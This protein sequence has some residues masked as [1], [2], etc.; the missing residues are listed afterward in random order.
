MTTGAA[1]LI[2]RQE[3]RWPGPGDDG[4]AGPEPA[5][6]PAPAP[7]PGFVVSTFSPL[8]AQ[9]AELVL[10]REYGAPPA[11]PARAEWTATVVV[12]RCGDVTSAAHVARSVDA[13]V[14]VAPP[15]FAQAAPSAVAGYLTARWGLHGPV[16]CLSPIGD[17]VSEGL[18]VAADLIDDGEADEALIVAAEQGIVHNGRDTARAIL[19]ARRGVGR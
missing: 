13:G 6:T 7:L 1:A 10:C 8:V 11:D 18:A 12:S 14:P 3:A 16:V 19:V 17:P 9:V 2:I 4:G 15:L 5:D